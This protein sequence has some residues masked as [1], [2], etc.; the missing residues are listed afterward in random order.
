MY[1]KI[2]FLT[3]VSALVFSAIYA[4]NFSYTFFNPP[5]FFSFD[6][7]V[8]PMVRS[9][10]EYISDR[11]EE[12]EL[13]EVFIGEDRI[14]KET[15]IIYEYLFA[16]DGITRTSRQKAPNHLVNLTRK[17]LIDRIEDFRIVSFSPV[18]VVLRKTVEANP[19]SYIIGI[20]N[21]R[22]A[23][24]RGGET[25]GIGLMEITD[26]PV[27]TLSEDEVNRLTEGIV[28][29][30]ELELMKVLEDYGS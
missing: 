29:E 4:F 14:T 16:P 17:Q 22:V 21:E 19:E 24:F 25:S 9:H 2:K 10:I 18:E 6:E 20:W 12:D 23:V 27:S 3:F 5:K 7:G 28:I 8:N 1:S 30:S 26:T 15:D 13:L 11:H